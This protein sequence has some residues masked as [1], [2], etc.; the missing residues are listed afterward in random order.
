MDKFHT[1]LAQ[2]D[3]LA[4]LA[5]DELGLVQEAVFLQLE[6]DQTGGHAGGVNGDV[7]VP[8]QI[9]DGADVV[10]MSVGEED[11]PN[12]VAVF[13]EVGKIGDNHVNA[14][15]I[16]VG[17]AHAY[18]HD[19]HI[20]AVLVDGQVFANLVQAAKGNNFQFFSHKSLETLLFIT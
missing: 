2:P 19:N 16:V 17:E 9:G 1:K 11:A 14:V 15:H 20:S 3:H 18:V 4:R 10:L 6:L 13:D 12:T 8:E 7:H 5:G